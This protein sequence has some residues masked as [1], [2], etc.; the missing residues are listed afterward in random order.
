[1]DNGLSPFCELL[2]EYSC[3]FNGY[4]TQIS[5]EEVVTDVM[6]YLRS[7]RRVD[8]V[9]ILPIE[10]VHNGKAAEVSHR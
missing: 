6:S 9:K 4:V 2:C 1:M 7:W 5:L 8:I 3:V 10:I